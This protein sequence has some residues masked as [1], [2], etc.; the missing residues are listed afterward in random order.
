MKDFSRWNERMFVKYNNLRLYKHPNPIIRYTESKRVQIM[1]KEL[2]SAG[3]ALDAGCGEGYV[4]S[5]MVSPDAVGL[6]ISRTAIERASKASDAT[7][8]LGDAE[9]MPF[10]DSYFDAAI[11]SETLEHTVNP[12]RVVEELSRVVRPGGKIILSTPNEKLI[13]TIKDIVWNLG[14]F[15]ILFPG[16][17]RKQNEEWH[18]H[19]F[20]LKMLKEVSEGLL[21]VDRIHA[22][23]FFF[24]PIR[25]VLVGTNRKKKPKRSGRLFSHN[26]KKYKGYFD[27]LRG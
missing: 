22:V 17:P 21:A 6:D 13:N 2:G 9:R 10:S 16:V 11:C 15:D 25:Y 20:D 4:L 14:L 26:V 8:V 12:R 3:R 19:S 7:L 5:K 23:P 1:L 27:S 18:L 24:L